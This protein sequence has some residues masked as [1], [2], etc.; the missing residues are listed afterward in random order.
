[1]QP[2]FKIWRKTCI[3][4][5]RLNTFLRSHNKTLKIRAENI[6]EALQNLEVVFFRKNYYTRFPFI[7]LRSYAQKNRKKIKLLKTP[8]KTFNIKRKTT[9]LKRLYK[10]TINH[11]KHFFPKKTLAMLTEMQMSVLY[12]W[13][14]TCLTFSSPLI[15]ALVICW[16]WFENKI[17]NHLLLLQSS[18]SNQIPWT[19]ITNKTISSN[20]KAN[21]AKETYQIISKILF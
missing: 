16:Y 19:E 4:V 1:M 11:L 8:F 7:V 9:Q 13:P 18:L 5:E 20:G 2:D 10:E 15:Y 12:F 21:R 14:K 6:P 17:M 3:P